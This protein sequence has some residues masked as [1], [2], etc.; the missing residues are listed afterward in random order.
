MHQLS[1]SFSFSHPVEAILAGTHGVA[2]DMH[3]RTTMFQD[4]AGTVPVTADGQPV[5]LVLSKWGTTPR[6]LIQ[7]SAGLAPTADPAGVLFD[8]VDDRLL[9]ESSVDFWRNVP[10]HFACL[11]LTHTN[12]TS[13][14]MLVHQAISSNAVTA[15]FSMLVNNIDQ[16][17]A[18]VRRPDG[19]TFNRARAGSAAAG[20]RNVITVYADLTDTLIVACHVNG[21]QQATNVVTAP[22]ANSDDT[23]AASGI[24]ISGQGVN[25]WIYGVMERLVVLP[26]MPT[27]EEINILEAWV[28]ET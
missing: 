20:V 5:A 14:Q 3:D 15:R 25:S 17:E 11:A 22:S 13:S 18:I 6:A 9:M 26:F 4:A 8:G 12:T 19:A 21:V 16:P 28:G 10:A 23:D 27:P 24:N 2:Y 7:G 1:V